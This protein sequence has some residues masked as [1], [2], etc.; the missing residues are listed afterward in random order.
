MYLGGLYM[1]L[2]YNMNSEQ[3][4]YKYLFILV[5]VCLLIAYYFD[6][7][8]QNQRQD[9]LVTT[10]RIIASPYDAVIFSISDG[11]DD[12]YISRAIKSGDATILKAGTLYRIVTEF[13][14]WYLIELV[15]RQRLYVS[16]KKSS[17][18]ELRVAML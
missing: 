4:K 7:K 8:E 6:L 10:N 11:A 17:E 18:G 3:P 15:T 5:P 9:W 13:P 16:K 2:D 1:L 12:S 14:D